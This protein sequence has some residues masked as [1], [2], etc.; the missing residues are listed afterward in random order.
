MEFL[1]ELL[2]YE[3]MEI[4]Q[5]LVPARPRASR[6]RKRSACPVCYRTMLKRTLH[7]H[8]RAT[9]PSGADT[10][11]ALA[12]SCT[13]CGETFSRKDNL[14]RHVI[15]Q[16]L[17]KGHFV[18]CAICSARVRVRSLEDHYK[19]SRCRAASQSRR[20]GTFHLQAW[21]QYAPCVGDLERFGPESL[22][23]PLSIAWHF[24]TSAQGLARR[25]RVALSREIEYLELR[26]LV[27]RTIRRHIAD[28]DAIS[29]GV[30]SLALLLVVFRDFYSNFTPAMFTYVKILSALEE[31]STS[32]YIRQL[33]LSDDHHTLSMEFLEWQRRE[34]LEQYV[35]GVNSLMETGEWLRI[36]GYSTL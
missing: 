12:S 32:P 24:Y 1:G 10:Q 35:S 33:S 30:I 13:E 2:S 26:G 11:L 3:P 6:E 36:C 21:Q 7:R 19:S 31:Q 8:L 18:E 23:N 20:G 16:H 15:T 28:Q 9:H 34:Y 27:M 22:L 17:D 14:V 5:G 4:E 25:G 29:A